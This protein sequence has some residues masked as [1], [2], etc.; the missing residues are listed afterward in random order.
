[1]RELSWERQER[2]Q[3]SRLVQPMACCVAVTYL[4]SLRCMYFCFLFLFY[5]HACSELLNVSQC[6]Y[7]CFFCFTCMHAQSCCRVVSYLY[8]SLWNVSQC[9]RFLLMFICLACRQSG[10]ASC[11]GDIWHSMLILPFFFSSPSPFSCYSLCFFLLP[12]FRSSIW[13]VVM[14]P[15][16][17]RWLMLHAV[18]FLTY[19]HVFLPL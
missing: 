17:G 4:Q 2:T 19:T 18:V 1:M 16:H 12:S 10:C 9:M 3:Q 11:F 5:L 6:M 7:F 15:C 13:C 14:S 8:F